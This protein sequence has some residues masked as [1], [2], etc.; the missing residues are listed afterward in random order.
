MISATDLRAHRRAAPDDRL[1]VLVLDYTC[2]GD[3]DWVDTLMPYLKWAY[4]ER[5]GVCL[6]KVG[7]KGDAELRA[8]RLLARSLLAPAIDTELSAAAGDSTPLAHG[9]EVALHTLRHEL[10]HGRN[11]VLEACLVVVTDG[12]GNVPLD[13]ARSGQPRCPVGRAGINDANAVAEQ[14]AA[15]DRVRRVVI[16]PRPTAHPDLPAQLAARLNAAVV[17]RD[18][19]RPAEPR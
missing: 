18:A 11:G 2:R 19:D 9:L 5:A 16:D 13:A 10:H 8:E 15:L 12:R 6:V 17:A 3:W 14:L 7:A 1:L 4:V